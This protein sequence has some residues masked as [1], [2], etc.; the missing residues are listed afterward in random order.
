M[1]EAVARRPWALRWARPSS[2]RWSLARAL[3]VVQK[4]SCEGFGRFSE[5]IR[6]RLSKHLILLG[7]AMGR[8]TSPRVK[9]TFHV[10]QK[11]G[12]SS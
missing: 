9:L 3:C 7:L 5:E 6:S 8:A 10:L 12:D 2:S 1:V 11:K 4:L